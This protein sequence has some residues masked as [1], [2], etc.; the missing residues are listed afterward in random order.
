MPKA[1]P[2]SGPI[3]TKL[4]VQLLNSSGES[5]GDAL[6]GDALSA[7]AENLSTL[8]ERANRFLGTSDFARIIAEHQATQM[9]RR[10]RA[11]IHVS[12]TGHAILSISYEGEAPVVPQPRQQ[13][14]R[15]IP[16]MVELRRR[17]A[18]MDVDIARFGIKRRE[19]WEH[20]QEIEARGGAKDEDRGPMSAGPDEVR[21][22]PP[23][24]EPPPRRRG[25][26]KTGDAVTAPVVVHV[27]PVPEAPPAPSQEDKKSLRQLVKD[28]ETVDISE[29]L[30]SSTPKQ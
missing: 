19:I 18:E 24:E 3:D 26:A 13:K 9:G 4:A 29:L 11:S 21:V 16:L 15:K 2:Y 12:E 1:K 27:D 22:S 7:A 20:L 25:I 8:V 5:F 30:R 17:A 10:G 28:S 14:T 23:P 6:L